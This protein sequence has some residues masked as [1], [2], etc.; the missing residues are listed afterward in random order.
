MRANDFE[1]RNRVPSRRRSAHFHG[2]AVGDTGGDVET[3]SAR[4]QRLLQNWRCAEIAR[5]IRNVCFNELG[6]GLGKCKALCYL[7][8]IHFTETFTEPVD[9]TF[10]FG[11]S[12]DE[13]E[14]QEGIQKRAPKSKR[15]RL[16]EKVSLQLA[17]VASSYGLVK[18]NPLVVTDERLIKLLIIQ[19]QKVQQ[20]VHAKR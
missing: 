2:G 5:Q 11:L 12:D 14:D 16:R 17:D 7:S 19:V 20:I 10:L 18:F 13:E 4:R 6:L 15:M 8:Y 3:K 1:P 9:L